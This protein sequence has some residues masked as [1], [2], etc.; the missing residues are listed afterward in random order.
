MKPCSPGRTL[1]EITSTITRT[2]G[3]GMTDRNEAK[4]VDKAR[5]KTVKA[6]PELD[7][8]VTQAVQNGLADAIKHKTPPPGDA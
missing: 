3:D 6:D 7:A 5:S 8:T 2:E 1:H 4:A